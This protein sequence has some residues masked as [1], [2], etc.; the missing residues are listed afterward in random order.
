MLITVY[1]PNDNYSTSHVTQ[2]FENAIVDIECCLQSMQ[3]NKV[4]I[5]GDFNTSF[6]RPNAQCRYL[7]NFIQRNDLYVT[8]NNPISQKETTYNN[9]ALNHASCIDH[10]IVSDNINK[11]LTENIVMHSPVNVSSHSMIKLS[12]SYKVEHI[13][14]ANVKRDQNKCNWAKAG[15]NNILNY[16]YTLDKC[17][18]SIGIP[19]ESLLCSDIMCDEPIHMAKLDTFCNFCLS[20]V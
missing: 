14:F 13:T 15:T 20:T 1:M 19:H 7:T 6:E 18:D 2:S 4:V 9:H 11:C 17:L 16:K 5:C 3:C 12:V 10:F 8:W